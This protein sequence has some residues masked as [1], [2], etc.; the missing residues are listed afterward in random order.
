MLVGFIEDYLR[1]LLALAEHSVVILL[2]YGIK[3]FN[4]K[5]KK[6]VLISLISDTLL[7]E[8]LIY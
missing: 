2:D 7:I 5:K 3:A 6:S 4:K 1:E 8:Q